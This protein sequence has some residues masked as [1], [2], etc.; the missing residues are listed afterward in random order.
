MRL[1]KMRRPH[2]PLGHRDH[3]PIDMAKNRCYIFFTYSVIVC[4]VVSMETC[5]TA[6]AL[7]VT[8]NQKMAAWWYTGTDRAVG[9]TSPAQNLTE[10]G[11]PYHRRHDDD[12]GRS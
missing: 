1:A 6:R 10:E 4:Y 9:D 8:L 2:I 3:Q 5:C 7:R 12:E 11:G